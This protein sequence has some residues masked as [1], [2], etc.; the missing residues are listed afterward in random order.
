MS[1]DQS[2][3]AQRQRLLE[4]LRQHPLSTPEIRRSLDIPAPAPR[5][6]ELREAGHDIVRQWIRTTGESGELHRFGLYVLNVSGGPKN[7]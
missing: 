2:A 5:I 1:K 4:G 7:V 6:F 3:V